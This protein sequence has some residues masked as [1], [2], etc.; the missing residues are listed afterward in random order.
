MSTRRCAVRG[1]FYPY[2]RKEVENYIKDFNKSFSINNEIFDI[3]AA[4]RNNF[5]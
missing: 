5:V 4:I 3:K 2:E 1:T